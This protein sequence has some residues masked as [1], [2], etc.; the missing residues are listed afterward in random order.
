MHDVQFALAASLMKLFKDFCIRRTLCTLLPSTLMGIQRLVT[1]RHTQILP[2]DN[3]NQLDL[4]LFLT[5]P[6]PR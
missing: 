3:H 2:L 5:V 6:V 1:L 4:H